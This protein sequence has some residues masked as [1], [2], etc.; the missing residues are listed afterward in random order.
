MD[1]NS[2]FADIHG[3]QKESLVIYLE[4]DVLDS[5][6]TNFIGIDEEKPLLNRASLL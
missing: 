2:V 3:D 4:N 6:S 1:I 5:V